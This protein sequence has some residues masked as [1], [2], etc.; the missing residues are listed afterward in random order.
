M[1]SASETTDRTAANIARGANI[2]RRDEADMVMVMGVWASS[3][4]TCLSESDANICLV[5]YTVH[6][7][8]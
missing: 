1:A 2:A 5:F 6:R 8:D 4:Q 3:W 7:N